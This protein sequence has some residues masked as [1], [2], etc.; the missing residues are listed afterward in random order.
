MKKF[1]VITLDARYSGYGKFKY[2]V[3]Y[4]LYGNLNRTI[5][6][7]NCRSWF[8]DTYGP[9]LEVDYIAHMHFKYQVP[10]WAWKFNPKGSQRSMTLYLK[11]DAMLSH[12]LLTHQQ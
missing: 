5:E 9:G 2:A 12:F 11:D 10:L 8:W 7:V 3:D 1:N 6:F 4:H